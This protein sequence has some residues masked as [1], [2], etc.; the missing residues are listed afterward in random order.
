[1]KMDFNKTR[2]V[3]RIGLLGALLGACGGP[4]QVPDAYVFQGRTGADSVAYSGQVFRN[5]LIDSMSGHLDR[6]TERLDTGFFP[7]KGDVE[8]ELAFYLDFDDATSAGLPHGV[9]TSPEPLQATF[10]EVASGKDLVG[11]LAGNDAVTDHVDWSTGLVGWGAPGSVSPEGLV[12]SWVAQIDEAATGWAA[13][14]LDPTG[15]PVP[16]VYVTADGLDLRQLLEKF[17][18]GAV[19]YSQGADDY[20]DDDVEGKGLLSDHTVVVEGEAYTA[21]EHAWDEGFGYFGAARDHGAWTLD[22]IADTRA[23][24][25]DGDGRI[26]L[27]SEWVAGHASNAAK[28]DRGAVDAVDLTQQAWRAFL[29]GRAL[30]DRTSGP[31][32]ESGQATLVAHRDA[33]LEAWEGALAATAVHYVNDAVQDLDAAGTEAWSFADHAKHWSELKGFALS[34]QFNPHSAMGAADFAR[35]HE[36]IGDR[37]WLP[38]AD[39]EGKAAARAAL[40]EARALL[41]QVHGFDERNLGDEDGLGGW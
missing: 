17:L 5:L 34:L 1:M 32:S 33:A 37:P 31:L 30:L 7:A 16:A 18:R 19:S 15:A 35:L 14:P 24:D 12:R 22:E 6:L 41:G 4:A 27:L 36:L 28:R 9:S 23:V 2:G 29:E 25:G 13:P 20:L 21:L 40:L 8:A 39:D 26:D 10:G 11:K 38:G 3:L